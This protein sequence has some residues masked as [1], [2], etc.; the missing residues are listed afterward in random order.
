MED[1]V[2]TTM[3][4][5]HSALGL[6]PAVHEFAGRLRAAGH[7]VVTPDLFNGEVFSNLKDGVAHR[8]SI[9]IPALMGRAQESVGK[10]PHEIVYAGF[11]MGA[12]SAQYLA[13][14]RPG[15]RGAI[16]M[17]AALPPAMMGI[18]QW[19]QVP[20]QVHYAVGD[21]WVEEAQVRTLSDSVR[22]A[23]Q[24]CDVYSYQGSGHL[25]ADD[26]TED[27]NEASARLMLNRV[28]KFLST[29]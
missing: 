25:F 8:D 24:S 17:Y 7:T 13:A 29:M 2:P 11:S 14:T 4:L 12:A 18:G 20:V 15:A 16:L 22:E 19:P 27:Y 6:R 1:P 9:G 21:P 28:L 3:V 10:L 26:D 23:G 5:F